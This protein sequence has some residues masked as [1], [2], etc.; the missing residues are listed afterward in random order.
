TGGQKTTAA[1]AADQIMSLITQFLEALKQK[2]A[3]EDGAANLKDL[4]ATIR[5]GFEQGYEEAMNLLKGM[6]VLS[7]DMASEFARIHDLVL[8]GLSDLESAQSSGIGSNAAAATEA[9]S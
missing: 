2:Q 9:N 3:G 7:D 6:G 4:V 8:K 1:G 5:D